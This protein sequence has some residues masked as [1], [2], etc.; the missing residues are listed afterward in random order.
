MTRIRA[1]QRP[2]DRN[3]AHWPVRPMIRF[4]SLPSGSAPSAPTHGAT[5]ATGCTDG[6]RQRWRSQTTLVIASERRTNPPWQ[7][8]GSGR[9]SEC[10]DG[11]R[12]PGGMAPGQ[13]ACRY[14]LDPESVGRMTPVRTTTLQVSGRS[15]GS[16]D[17]PRLT[18]PAAGPRRVP[19]GLIFFFDNRIPRALPEQ[20]RAPWRS[21]RPG[22]GGD[23]LAR[24]AVSI[25][26]AT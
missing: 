2:S 10:P 13:T 4:A 15:G 7:L 8:G 12:T 18:P 3:W 25:T 14:Q 26:H 1:G 23:H 22:D 11:L 5:H 21:L 19:R 9:R 24:S 6:A 20:V 16:A 17:P